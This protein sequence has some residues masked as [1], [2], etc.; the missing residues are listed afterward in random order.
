M[1]AVRLRHAVLVLMATSGAGCGS[2]QGDGS[3]ARSAITP[4]AGNRDFPQVGKVSLFNGTVNCS[5]TL[6]QDRIV[7]TAAHCVSGLGQAC[8]PHTDPS[9]VGSFNR[10]R[11][12]F[13]GDSSDAE[14][15]PIDDVATFPEAYDPKIGECQTQPGS[16]VSCAADVISTNPPG[17]NNG[18]FGQRFGNDVAVLHLKRTPRA[19]KSGAMRPMR[20]ITSFD[21][22]RDLGF[23]LHVNIDEAVSFGTTLF[24]F[25]NGVVPTLVGFDKV[26]VRS[27]G[28]FTFILGPEW[29]RLT[30]QLRFTCATP[31]PA[32]YS[33]FT[34][35]TV[36]TGIR[37]TSGVNGPFVEEGDSGGPVIVKDG[38][39][40]DGLYGVTPP[41][42]YVIGVISGD[43]HP[44]ERYIAGKTF[45]D[46]GAWLDRMLE[47][48]DSD[49]KPNPDDNCPK[50]YNPLQENCN[51]T[52]EL[53][54]KATIDAAGNFDAV[55]GDACDP[56]PCP[57][58]TKL[59][60]TR[61]EECENILGAGG[62]PTG[63]LS[64]DARVITDAATSTPLG[65]GAAANKDPGLNGIV[66]T[67]R[68]CQQQGTA[69]GQV[70]CK[71]TTVITD[72]QLGL[73]ESP[74]NPAAPWHRVSFGTRLRQLFGG[75]PDRGA[76]LLMN[77][78]SFYT[79]DTL[80]GV[81][82]SITFNQGFVETNS[83][84]YQSDYK[85]WTSSPTPLIPL[86]SDTAFCTG[87]PIP[88]TCL[89]GV[90]WLNAKT[91]IGVTSHGA[92]L[93]NTYFDWQPD[94]RRGGYCR[95]RLLPVTSFASTSSGS[96]AGAR[97]DTSISFG[98]GEMLWP[99]AGAA[100]TFEVNPQ[101]ETQLVRPAPFGVAAALQH[102][103][104]SIALGPDPTPC[105]GSALSF[106]V[107]TTIAGRVWASAVEPS[108]AIGRL[109]GDVLAVSLSADAT[110]V[111]EGVVAS[112]SDLVLASDTLEF[113][114][115]LDSRCPACDLDPPSPRTNFLSLLSRAAGGLFVVGG[116]D[117]SSARLGDVWFRTP[118]FGWR[119]V[120]TDPVPLG[121]LLD[122]TYPFGSGRLW[123]LDEVP[124]NLPGIHGTD[125]RI[126]RVGIRGEGTGVIF[127]APRKRSET[128]PFMSVDIDG[129]VLFA[130]ARDK[131]F[132][133]ARV[134][135][136]R[137]DRLVIEALQ[138][139]QGHLVRRPIIDQNGY[140]FVVT[141]PDG[142]LRIMRLASLRPI[143]CGDDPDA[144]PVEEPDTSSTKTASGA[145]AA[146]RKDS[147]NLGQ[148]PASTTLGAS[149]KDQMGD[150]ECDREALARLF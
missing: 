23:A 60:G 122:A 145:S 124:N 73:M 88:G 6:V 63:A 127:R 2:D 136:D 15:I 19:I 125:V 98:V 102:D 84:F 39:Q 25:P 64:C 85:F 59:P 51:L 71:D 38:S 149:D 42:Q 96:A 92:E 14:D 34:D 35:F 52:S 82:G 57:K 101:P 110:T 114:S 62:L 89:D 16:A 61:E 83:W 49:S 29:K 44:H 128:T 33:T 18:P 106:R 144:S 140:S 81:P 87:G 130:M 54:H 67:P 146:H 17:D 104:S 133:L 120:S 99:F 79:T 9:Y 115:L 118:Q 143:G 116:T 10:F 55:L 147:K 139:V 30:D 107:A 45:D 75:I 86:P 27:S 112:G 72:A 142:S 32:D 105:N 4:S 65:D 76:T 31:P 7:L 43:D 123:I 46:V 1:H 97:A 121:S 12:T 100:L 8:R 28:V 26:E 119:Q 13:A 68:F 138:P 93:A 129:S 108:P 137:A 78:T 131:Q 94:A 135:T 90:F 113:R 69:P 150:I 74:S 141:A 58:S 48:W 50:D 80:A 22:S 117:A 47:D 36:S 37:I 40:A 5:G 70:N 41:G 77:Y 21:E 3:T 95:E 53:A 24:G 126:V 91:S 103:G 132:D 11:V 134:R 66:T 56:V 109:S 20:V 111:Q 148:G